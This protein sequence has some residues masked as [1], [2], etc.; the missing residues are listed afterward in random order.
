MAKHFYVSFKYINYGLSI[1]PT[2]L[3]LDKS[4]NFPFQNLEIHH[5]NLKESEKVLIHKE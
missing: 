2:V 4:L 5:N 1:Y 3:I